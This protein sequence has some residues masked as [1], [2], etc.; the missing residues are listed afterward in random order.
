M[1]RAVERAGGA[2]QVGL[3]LPGITSFLEIH[4]EYIGDRGGGEK[5]GPWKNAESRAKRAGTMANYEGVMLQGDRKREGHW[6]HRMDYESGGGYS[7]AW[8][9]N[10][11]PQ[12]LACSLWGHHWQPLPRKVW[13]VQLPFGHLECRHTVACFLRNYPDSLFSKNRMLRQRWSLKL[14]NVQRLMKRIAVLFSFI[15]IS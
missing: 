3:G 6:R 1:Q 2:K 10:C 7:S 9:E 12:S 13:L 8:Q 15:L 11:G 14:E 4:N 5:K